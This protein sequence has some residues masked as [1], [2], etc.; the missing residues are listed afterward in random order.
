MHFTLFSLRVPLG[1]MRQGWQRHP[2]NF[3]QFTSFLSSK[4]DGLLPVCAVS[5]SSS[6]I[7]KII[8]Y[9]EQP[10]TGAIKKALQK[11]ERLSQ[12]MVLSLV[13]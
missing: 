4:R 8:R 7:E 10:D 9:S 5:K 3:F 6:I 12:K 11:F 2:F 13:S 1:K